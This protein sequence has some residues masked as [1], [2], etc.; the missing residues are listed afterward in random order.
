MLRLVEPT[1]GR[2]RF[3]GIEITRL[4][5]GDLRKLRRRMQIIFQDPHASLDPR[6]T[7]RAVVAEGLD[8]FRLAR[9]DDRE[10]RVRAALDEVGLGADLLDRYPGELSGGQRQ[11]IAIARAMIVGPELVVCDEPTSALDV[12]VGAQIVNLLER[13]QEARQL[14]YVFISH[15]L[16]TVERTSHRIAVMYL[17]KIVEIGPATAVAAERLHPYTEALFAAAPRLAQRGR[18]EERR[19]LILAGEPPHGS[20]PPM[21]C[22]FHP[23][24]PIMEKGHC[25]VE[26]PELRK[27]GPDGH[28]V[29]CFK[30]E[31]ATG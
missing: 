12:S 11:R 13:A 6:M 19:R 3:D 1:L 27:L 16:R 7:L 21:G 15:D 24:C 22:A 23:R 4:G 18:S 26:T 20:K 17:G 14:S 8:H 31:S 29:A 2:V 10:E 28:E 5:D 9:G 25:D 30:V